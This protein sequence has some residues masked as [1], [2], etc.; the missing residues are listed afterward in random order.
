MDVNQ[1]PLESDSVKDEVNYAEPIKPSVQYDEFK[2]T[3]K[4]H[5]SIEDT[6]KKLM[7]QNKPSSPNRA[8]KL[9]GMPDKGKFKDFRNTILKP[10]NMNVKMRDRMSSMIN[11]SSFKM[12]FKPKD[13]YSKNNENLYS[14]FSR[15]YSMERPDNFQKVQTY[16]HETNMKNKY[17]KRHNFEYQNLFRVSQ[18]HG[19]SK[20]N[21]KKEMLVNQMREVFTTSQ[22][23]YYTELRNPSSSHLKNMTERRQSGLKQN[24]L[25]FSQ[26]SN[27]QT[28]LKV[29]V[30]K[31]IV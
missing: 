14:R 24:K 20:S 11:A 23:P 27:V 16:N 13:E 15:E 22:K 1:L 29:S 2:S 28:M 6:Y 5:S 19:T 3:F 18:I 30:S 31:P 4:R 25:L 17:S 7:I 21:F 12:K 26:T 8:N 9:T 10:S